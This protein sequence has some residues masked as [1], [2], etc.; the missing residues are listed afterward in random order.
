MVSPFLVFSN[1]FN[2]FFKFV[3]LKIII[4][5]MFVIFNCFGCFVSELLDSYIK[6]FVYC[7]KLAISVAWY[8]LNFEV[9]W[10]CRET[11][12]YPMLICLYFSFFSMVWII[13]EKIVMPTFIPKVDVY[14]ILLS[15]KDLFY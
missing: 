14:S 7:S 12:S 3:S 15:F 11:P 5:F 2:V 1:C 6:V 13:D 9:L 4:V 8:F 10:D